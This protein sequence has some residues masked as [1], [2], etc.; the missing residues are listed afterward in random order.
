MKKWVVKALLV[1]LATGTFLSGVSVPPAMGAGATASMKK[2]SQVSKP[3]RQQPVHDMVIFNDYQVAGLDSNGWNWVKNDEFI[4]PPE[5]PLDIDM[6]Q[7]TYG[8]GTNLNRKQVLLDGVELSEYQAENTSSQTS[9]KWQVPRFTI[10]AQKLSAGSHTL[11]FIVTDAIGKSSTLHVRFIV[12]AKNYPSIFNGEKAE[13]EPVPS[14]GQTAI[15]GMMGSHDFASSVPGTWKLTNKSTSAEMRSVPATVFSTGT[16]LTGQYELLFVPDD[17]AMSSWMTTIQVGVAELYMGTDAS[18]QKLTQDQKITAPSAP[19]KVPLFS[20]IPGRWSVNG[21]GQTLTDAQ[22]FE[23]DIPERLAG[24]T[25]AVTFEPVSGQKE[26]SSL[27]GDTSATTVQIQIP[28]APNACGPANGNVTMD[29]LMKQN[30]Q[31]TPMVEKMNLY[32]SDNTI[33]LYQNPVHVIWLATAADHIKYGSEV[34]DDEGPGVWA[35]DNV[36][37]DESKLSWDHT[38]LLLSGYK[39]GRYKVNYYSKRDPAQVWCGYVQVIEDSSPIKTYPTCEPDDTGVA[40]PSSPLILRSE[41]GKEYRDGQ[42]ITVNAG[43]DLEEWEDLRLIATH[44]ELVGSKKIRDKSEKKSYYMPKFEWKH[45]EIGMGASRK[46][47]N[48]TISS[49]NRIEIFFGEEEIASIKPS[50][51][52]GDDGEGLESL[53]LKRYIDTDKPGEYK[54]KVTNTLSNKTCT[55]IN[56]KRKSTKKTDENERNETLTITI[57]VK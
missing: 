5:T 13:G 47:S 51:D 37:A 34:D 56:S 32:S 45:G 4:L 9:F 19:G 21:T 22:H 43:D 14:G 7:T 6:I 52:D 15:F 24:I 55:V 10:P 18:G 44:A 57:E 8:T 31:S 12:E 40:P 11:T 49:E 50:K 1:C 46:H 42:K 48:G 41:S 20:P 2:N 29:V 35:I 25:I 54:I 3:L 39:P 33:K 53:N 17:T 26:T 30:E 36:I 23:V 28:G 38:A 16:L 27:W